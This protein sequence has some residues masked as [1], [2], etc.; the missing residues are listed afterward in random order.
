MY[1]NAYQKYMEELTE[2]YGSLL[3][4]Q[5]LKAVNGKFS[6]ELPNL[7]GYVGQMCRFGDYAVTPYGSEAIF[8]LKGTEPNYDMI[9]SFE[10]LMSF[11]PNVVWH[12]KSRFPISICA[13]LHTTEHDKELFIIPVRRGE[14]KNLS[15]FADDKF[16][17][18]KCIVVVFLLETEEQMLKIHTKR[19]VCFA[20]VKKDGVVFYKNN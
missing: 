17:N 20:F 13:F 5:L 12:G 19:G 14:E 2:E 16:G 9:R 3:I 4:S 10:V 15:N 6:V 18:E 7:D 8:H 1:L 11:F